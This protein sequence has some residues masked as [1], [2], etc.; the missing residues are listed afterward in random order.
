MVH[1]GQTTT[2]TKISTE[3]HVYR[4]TKNK[5]KTKQN[6]KNC[7]E[8]NCKTGNIILVIVD[9]FCKNVCSVYYSLKLAMC[10]TRC[11]DDDDDD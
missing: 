8:Q 11:D 3:I 4:K 1:T 10:Q 5:T 6:K 2:T 9:R 7:R